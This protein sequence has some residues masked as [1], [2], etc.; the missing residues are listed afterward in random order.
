MDAQGAAAR[1]RFVVEHGA[2]LK[3]SIAAKFLPFFVGEQAQAKAAALAD[4]IFTKA[5]DKATQQMSQAAAQ[6]PA[7]APPDLKK[8]V[9]LAV[10]EFAGTAML[11]LVF[12][13][14]VDFLAA[15]ESDLQHLVSSGAPGTD[16][17]KNLEVAKAALKF[18]QGWKTPQSALRE[19]VAKSSPTDLQI[20][21]NKLAAVENLLKPQR[22]AAAAVTPTVTSP[23]ASS[24]TPSPSPIPAA[25]SQPPPPSSSSSS[26]SSSPSPIPTAPIPSP[27]TL[28]PLP[29]STLPSPSAPPT[30]VP[31]GDAMVE[32]ALASSEQ[33]LQS[34]QAKMRDDPVACIRRMRAICQTL[35][36]DYNAD[37]PSAAGKHQG[38][39]HA[40][41]AAASS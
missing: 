24:Q 13:Q 2:A 34:L 36:Q 1:D 23:A 30:S 32:A 41:A 21:T 28:P 27:S 7:A 6:A 40:A 25:S 16:G 39:P 19:K 17:A 5:L 20:L 15:H 9:V 31:D 11:Q 14:K 37:F 8:M 18:L 33:L 3:T 26:P 4:N 29:S 35:E 38:P 22:P 10:N 12:K